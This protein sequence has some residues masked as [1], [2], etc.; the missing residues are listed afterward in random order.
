MRFFMNPVHERF[1][2]WGF[3]KLEMSRT[4]KRLDGC[5]LYMIEI[6]D[7]GGEVVNKDEENN[8]VRDC[9]K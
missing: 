9:S 1:L 4:L 3:R 7:L 8:E 2:N 6:G 5:R